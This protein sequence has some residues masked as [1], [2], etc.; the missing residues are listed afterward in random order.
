MQKIIKDDIISKDKWSFAHDIAELE[1]YKKQTTHIFLNYT[2]WTDVKDNLDPD[3][4][5]GVTLNSDQE[6]NCLKDDL[7]KL[8]AIALNFS[9]FMDGRNFS[10][11]RELRESYSFVGEIRVIG[12][13]IRDQLFFLKRCGVNVFQFSNDTDLEAALGSLMDFSD[14]YQASATD[15]EPLFRRR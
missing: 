1:N 3:K 9:T 5:W 4:F 8:S 15:R 13:F 2:L 14:A 7:H 12:D 11:A 10:S 6:P